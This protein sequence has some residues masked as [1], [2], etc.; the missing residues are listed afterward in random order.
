MSKLKLIGVYFLLAICFSN[1]EIEFGTTTNSNDFSIETD[2]SAYLVGDDIN[3][4]IT[5]DIEETANH[6]MC[7]NVDLTYDQILKQT[8]DN[9]TEESNFVICTTMGPMGFFGTL[10]Q[11][12]MKNETIHIDVEGTYKLKYTFIVNTDTISS[13]SNEFTVGL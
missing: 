12:E 9:W 1:C 5:N 13:F 8:D 10:V 3:V 6:Y 7:D 4:N 11:H 2:E